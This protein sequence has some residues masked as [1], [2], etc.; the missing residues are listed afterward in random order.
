MDHYNTL[1]VPRDAS[2][3]VIRKAYKKLVSTYHP[4]RNPGNEEAVR[5]FKQVAEAFDVLGD[6]IKKAQ[7]DTL[8]YV[9]RRPRNSPKP[10]PKKQPPKPQKTKEDFEKE[11]ETKRERD[12]YREKRYEQEPTHVNCTFFGGSTT[13]RNILVHLKLTA[14]ERQYGCVKSVPVKRRD[15]CVVCGGDGQGDFT[16]PRCRD[17]FPHRE[18]CPVCDGFGHREMQCQD[19]KG[20]GFGLWMI[21]DITVK[22]PANTK[23]GHQI[24]IMGGGEQ[25]PRKIPGSL[26]VV[27]V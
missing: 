4:D 13:G 16:C 15:F 19:C 27:V 7:Y 2:Q 22:I 23:P 8:G 5:R 21:D 10:P 20:T 11:R 9:G 1:G 17:K 18:V 24:N 26:R 3:E 12:E 14:H 25:A 6:T